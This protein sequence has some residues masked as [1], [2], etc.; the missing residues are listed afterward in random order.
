MA[1]TTP[2]GI[3]NLDAYQQGQQDAKSG[4]ACAYPTYRNTDW[5]P[6]QYAT[7]YRLGYKI[8]NR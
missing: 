5:L 3:K 6:E 7:D 1:A 4:K 8:D 2:V